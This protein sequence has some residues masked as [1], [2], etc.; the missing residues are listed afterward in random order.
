M[1]LFTKTNKFILKQKIRVPHSHLTIAIPCCNGFFEEN[2]GKAVEILW[3]KESSF[4]QSCEK[5]CGIV[6]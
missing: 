4:P 2:C 5:V 6:R 1:K 3:K